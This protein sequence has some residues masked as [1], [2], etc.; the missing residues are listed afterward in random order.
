MGLAALALV[1]WS[2]NRRRVLWGWRGA[3]IGALALLVLGAG[4]CCLDQ[5]DM[6]QHRASMDLCSM[7]VLI[8]VVNV[9]VGTLLLLGLAPTL[10]APGFATILL[11]VPKPP[12][13]RFRCS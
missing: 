1:R 12:P 6:D 5:D 8:L 7:A 2:M 3:A 4:F 9:S 10:S 11:A 13:R